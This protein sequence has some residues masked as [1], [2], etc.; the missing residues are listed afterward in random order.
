MACPMSCYKAV[1]G[2]LLPHN[3]CCDAALRVHFFSLYGLCDQPVLAVFTSCANAAHIESLSDSEAQDLAHN[4]FCS[5]L[6]S[7]LPTPPAPKG[8]HVTR[9]ATDKYSLGSYSHMLTGVSEKWNREE[10]ST[11]VESSGGNGTFVIRVPAAVCRRNWQILA[12]LNEHRHRRWCGVRS[13]SAQ[14]MPWEGSFAD[15]RVQL[16]PLASTVRINFK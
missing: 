11:P 8:V 5:W 15:Q 3:C 4:T 12:V 1:S 16:H 9:W 6:P 14:G 13:N 7:H 10:F 2:L